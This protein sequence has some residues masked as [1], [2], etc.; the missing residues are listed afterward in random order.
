[1]GMRNT[2]TAIGAAAVLLYAALGWA[3]TSG[4]HEDYKAMVAGRAGAELVGNKTC[5][6]CHMNDTHAAQEGAVVNCEDCHGAG[7]LAVK[8][9]HEEKGRMACNYKTFINISELPKPAQ[10][11]VCIKCHSGNA[12]FNLHNWNAGA[13]NLNGVSCLDCHNMHHGDNLKPSRADMD[14]MCYNCHQ[15]VRAQFMLPTHHAVP[16]GK[17]A[18]VDC[19]NPHGSPNPGPMLL[20]QTVKETCV[21][22]HA[23]KEGPFVFEHSD[24]MEDCTACHF[25]HGSANDNLLAQRMPYLC[26]QCHGNHSM[27]TED[28]SRRFGTNCTDCHSSIHGSD[29]NGIGSG[30]GRFLR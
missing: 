14:K 3:G 4:S 16:E 17:V 19:H 12:T 18:C 26:L 2:L 9:L 21:R 30:N 13:H 24:V 5:W 8:D 15:N 27:T 29:L 20:R 22:C 23:E 10:S 25:A 7:D 28:T 1:M 11:M 6:N